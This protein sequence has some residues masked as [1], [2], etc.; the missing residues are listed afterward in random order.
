MIINNQ[1]K[2]NY[3]SKLAVY[4]II[5]FIFPYRLAAAELITPGERLSPSKVVEIAI[6]MHPQLLS[7]RN[8]VDV[9]KSR[10]GQ[11]RAGYFPQ[12]NL[13]AG[14]SRN[15]S[16]ILP[17]SY[18]QYSQ[19][20]SL[21]QNIYDFNR[22]S[23]KVNIQNI[24]LDAARADLNNVISNIILGVKQAYYEVLRARRARD[25]SVETVRQFEEQLAKAKGFYEVGTKPV[26]DV[27]T[28]E[29]NLGN[30]QVNLLKAENAVTLA[31]VILNNAMGMP[32]APPYELEDVT[33]LEK[34]QL[35]LKAALTKAFQAREDLQSLIKQKESAQ[36]AIELAQKDY[37]PVLTGNA[38]YGWS[39]EEFPLQR[40]WNIGAT[41]N[42][43]LFGGFLTKYQV[44]QAMAS[45][46]VSKTAEETLR[47]T[48]RLEVEQAH[49]NI[50][51]AEK[52][53]EAAQI[54]VRQA[55]ENIELA[56][57]RYAAGIGVPLELTTAVV[58]L[59]NAKL[60]LSGAIYDRKEAEA[61]LQMAMGER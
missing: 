27:T 2:Q 49:A 29:V 18:N 46:E 14:M 39:G 51:T 6:K 38:N 34:S 36:K 33:V 60:A 3:F 57:G 56:Q 15:T 52:S 1:S 44:S 8:T 48:I 10:I 21:N 22:V 13:T 24:N 59:G 20:L 30:A 26:F 23:T 31:F 40:G 11:A 7:A 45:Y 43:N 54:T 12:I 5:L 58:A 55:E 9:A 19:S 28:A 17:D 4:S 53:I 35:D 16:P 41:L 50:Q 25:I 37:L 47:Q 42:F 32:A 61:S